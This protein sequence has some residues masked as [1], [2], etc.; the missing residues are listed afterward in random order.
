MH[1]DLHV[2]SASRVLFC[3][4]LAIRRLVY[5]VTYS[6]CPSQVKL[7]TP[8]LLSVATSRSR[9]QCLTDTRNQ[10]YVNPIDLTGPDTEEPQQEDV[11]LNLALAPSASPHRTTN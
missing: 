4:F 10:N 7:H 8:C 3:S 2:L 11:A 1:H 6:Q 5:V 9:V